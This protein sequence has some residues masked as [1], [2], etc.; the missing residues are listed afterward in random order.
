M[1]REEKDQQGRNGTETGRGGDGGRQAALVGPTPRKMGEGYGRGE[2][3]AKLVAPVLGLLQSWPS[4]DFKSCSDHMEGGRDGEGSLDKLAHTRQ[5]F[6]QKN[7]VKSSCKDNRGL[8]AHTLGLSACL[9]F[10]GWW[11]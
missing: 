4:L 3:R 9:L 11:V 5:M 1:E 8:L 10:L 6:A 2:G 7:T